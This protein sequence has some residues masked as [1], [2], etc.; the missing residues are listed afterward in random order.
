[1]K[2]KKIKLAGQIQHKSLKD[3]FKAIEQV[4]GE[5]H[6]QT[7]EKVKSARLNR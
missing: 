3:A 2:K 1:M 5:L 6:I 7:T 4:M